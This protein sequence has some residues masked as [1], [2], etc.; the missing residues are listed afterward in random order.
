L[1]SSSW[2]DSTDYVFPG[3]L[4]VYKEM[5]RENEEHLQTMARLKE[6]IEEIKSSE[7]AQF[8]SC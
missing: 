5:E 2:L 7:Q 4:E 1:D 6:R 8:N 3:L